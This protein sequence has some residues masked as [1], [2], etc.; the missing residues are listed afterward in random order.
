MRLNNVLLSQELSHIIR[1]KDRDE[2]LMN[3]YKNKFNSKRKLRI[4]VKL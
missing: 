4:N 3:F 1:K 2:L